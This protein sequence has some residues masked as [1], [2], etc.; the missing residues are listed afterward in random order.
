M[1]RQDQKI[2]DLTKEVMML[3]KQHKANNIFIS[4]LIESDAEQTQYQR[5]TVVQNLCKDKLGLQ[6]EIPIRNAF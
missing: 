6:E 3:R 4:G 5:I 2:E 1:I